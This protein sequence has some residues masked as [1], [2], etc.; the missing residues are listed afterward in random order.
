MSKK[1]K[2]EGKQDNGIWGTA[3]PGERPLRPIEEYFV[4]VE[5]AKAERTP[6]LRTRGRSRK[7][8][9]VL[10]L[11]YGI[12]HIDVTYGTIRVRRS[13]K[14]TDRAVAMS[15]LNKVMADL[16][17]GDTGERI[18]P[19]GFDDLVALMKADYERRELRSWDRVM[20]A[21]PHLKRGF[22]SLPAGSISHKTIAQY[23]GKRDREGASGGTIRAEVAYLK[24]ALRLAAAEGTIR[25]MPVF[26]ALPAS[27]PRQGF[28]E[29]SEVLA[30]VA[31]LA[32]PVNDLILTLW[33]TGWR[34]DEVRLLK[35]SDVNM[36]A[37]E[38]RLTE[39]RSK[40]GKPRVFP[41]AASPSLGRMMKA[42]F[43][44]RGA[45]AVYVFER[46]PG[47]QVK[48]FRDAWERAC[49][50]AGVPGRIVHDLRRSR[51]RHLSRAG[52]PERTIMSI[53]GWTTAAMLH[54]YLIT[55]GQD[56]AEA[57]GR[58][59]SGTHRSLSPDEGGRE[60]A[61]EGA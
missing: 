52:V 22:G 47:V 17:R 20:D 57:I 7:G 3:R 19:L 43:V 5:A 23:M 16:Q 14:T 25:S 27:P 6:K 34:R 33:T 37:G 51:A 8:L 60:E 28:M 1:E 53:C 39:A 31:A 58:V 24:R 41:F 44:S 50:A 13:A 2:V 42:R 46:A 59:E 9:G 26:P 18:K 12:Y 35:W 15:L 30:I 36:N 4:E 54:R 56:I 10:K 11:R 48:D 45:G 29:K 61:S 55:S 38:I 40:T 21:V 32:S 49:K